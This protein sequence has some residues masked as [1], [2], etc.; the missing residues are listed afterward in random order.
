MP[1]FEIIDYDDLSALEQAL[2]DPHVAGFMLEPI[3]G[4]AG[5]V[6]PQPGYL[7]QAYQLC[8]AKNVLFIADEV[9]TG[10]GRT[11]KLLAC[12]H[13]GVKP[14]ILILGKAL[15]GGVY[16]VSAVL[17]RHEIMLTLR[18]GEHGSTFG[19]NPLACEV[20]LAALAVVRDERL[21]ENAERMG[22]VFRARMAHLVAKTDLLTLV[23]GKGLL[24]ALVVNDGPDSHTAWNLCL[25]LMQNGLLA[26]PTHGN[27]IRFA[28]PL[29]ITEE[30]MHECC[31]IIERTV[32]GFKG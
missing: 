18:P 2:Q 9:Q 5:V 24:N 19:G 1:G 3:Q 17:A 30:Q 7:R 4:E 6:V 15:S 26:K 21:P 13:E 16:P 32:L 29:V 11:G 28:P 31:D 27:I 12:E 14:D 10:I 8:R 23:R 25:Q 22:Q 20:A